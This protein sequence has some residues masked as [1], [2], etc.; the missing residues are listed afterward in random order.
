VVLVRL[1]DVEVRTF[2]L[3]EAVLAVKLELSGDDRVL[4]P[5]VHVE[6]S[7]SKNEC[8]SIR[9]SRSIDNRTVVRLER[10]VNRKSVPLGSSVKTG[11]INGTSHLEETLRGDEGLGAGSLSR[12]T[13]GVD[14]VRKSINGISVVERLSA[15]DLEKKLRSIERRAIINVSIRLDDPN[16]LLN[17]VVEVELDL[18]GR[19]TD[20]LVTSEL[21]LFDQ[22]FVRVLCHLSA[23]ISVEENVINIERSSNKRLLVSSCDRLGTSELRKGIDS[24]KTFTNRTDVKVNLDLVVLESNQR[25][26]KTRVSAEPKLERNV[27]CGLRK[28]VSW[29]AHLGRSASSSTRTSNRGECRI[30]QVGKLSGVTNHLEVPTLLFACHGNLVP[31]MHPVTI[32][33]VNALTS[34]LDLNLSDKLLSNK[35]QP[36]SIDTESRGRTSHRLVNLR[37]SDLKVCAVSKI[38]ISRDGAGNASAEIGLSGECLLDRLHSEVGVA[39]VRH[40]P[41]SNLRGSSKEH[42]L[43]AVG[44]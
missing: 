4:T 25:K 41:E 26:S 19:R 8:S 23:L 21:D 20:R 30:R 5:A 35:V 1:D 9:E 37:K 17:R 14:G 29:G 11:D 32:L 22:V 16:K 18:V 44:D 15:K 27:E 33:T 12:S 34:N 40:L 38:S 13:E 2:A 31:D 24:P 39:S 36:S 42:V 7:L 28:S 3:R 10:C 6:G 43:C